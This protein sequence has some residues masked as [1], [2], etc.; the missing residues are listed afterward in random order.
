MDLS[1]VEAALKRFYLAADSA[2]RREDLKKAREVTAL[3][4]ELARIRP[5]RRGLL[6]DAAAGHGYVGLLAAELLGFDQ[7][8]LLESS[9]ERLERAERVARAIGRAGVEVKAG[10]V[11]SPT[12]W[13]NRCDVV[14]GLHACGAASDAI[15]DRSLAAETRWLLLVPCC[16]GEA[17][18]FFAAAGALAD[19]TGIARQSE[20]R[21]RFVQAAIDS[22]RVLRLE[23][24]GYEVTVVP[25]LPPTVTPHNLL[26]RCRRVMEPTKMAAARA[27]LSTLLAR[28]AGTPT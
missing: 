21:R 8:T 3:L 23:A 13:P 20:V 2:L 1:L 9:P 4:G 14:V 25:L 27:Q 12:V 6:I 17:I 15:L 16:Y 24:A 7:V 26:F 5:K 18:P 11:S 19:R 28:N 22:Q 10:D